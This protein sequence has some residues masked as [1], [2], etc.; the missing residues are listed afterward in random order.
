MRKKIT[1]TILILLSMLVNSR[2]NFA[3]NKFRDQLEQVEILSN[4]EN[5]L[6][7]CVAVGGWCFSTGRP[8][9]GLH[10]I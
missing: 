2:L 10:I 3:E 1:I 8:T 5:A 6:S 7:P 4:P 9:K